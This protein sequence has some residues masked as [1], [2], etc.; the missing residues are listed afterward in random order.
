MFEKFLEYI[1]VNIPWKIEENIR[2]IE[3]P[4]SFYNIESKKFLPTEN[5]GTRNPVKIRT[6]HSNKYLRNGLMGVH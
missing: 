6:I 2:I 4:D 5:N 3:Y 1:D